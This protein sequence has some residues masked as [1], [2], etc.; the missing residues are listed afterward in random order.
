MADHEYLAA[1]LTAVRQEFIDYCNRGEPSNVHF[2]CR[3]A[4]WDYSPVAHRFLRRIVVK[5][6]KLLPLIPEVV[7]RQ[8]SGWLHETTPET[9][10]YRFLLEF[11]EPEVLEFSGH[12][13]I[14]WEG[15][16]IPNRRVPPNRRGKRRGGWLPRF[17]LYS[18]N[19]IDWLLL[20]I[21][22]ELTEANEETP[23]TPKIKKPRRNS[24]KERDQWIRDQEGTDKHVLKLLK[25]MRESTHSHWREIRDEERIR[26]IRNTQPETE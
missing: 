15:E 20:R 9:R 12:Q 18:I 19:A 16:T 5:A 2:T 24:N 8:P 23:A 7:F 17:H 26:Q 10:W 6:G 21:E 13:S 1:K 14:V 3:K 4:A 11:D 25:Q 22:E